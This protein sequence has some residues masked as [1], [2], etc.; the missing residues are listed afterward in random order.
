MYEKLP[1]ELKERGAFC[2]WKY[3]ERDGNRTKVPYQTNG[4]RANSA[5]KATFTNYAIAV[6]HRAGYD[7][8]GIGVFGD[9]CAID[10]D[11][12]LGIT[13]PARSDGHSPY[14]WDDTTITQIF[15]R[16]EYLGHTV[17]FKTRTKSFRDKK[18]LANDPSEWAVF[19]N[20]HDAIID[21]E[22]FDIV[23]RIREGRRRVTPMGE[24]PILSG[25]LFCAD[26][27]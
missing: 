8:I 20:T 25:M 24:M 2:L 16:Q 9:I 26:C 14:G 27:G 6:R 10:I 3:E 11:K 23:Q 19:E 1:Q 4:L 21:Q 7:G 22:S 18:K 13:L 12:R 5:N 17:N 15:T